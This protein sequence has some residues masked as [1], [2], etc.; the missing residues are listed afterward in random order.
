MLSGTAFLTSSRKIASSSLVQAWY[1]TIGQGQG[2][3]LGMRVEEEARRSGVE[4]TYSFLILGIILLE[5][6][7]GLAFLRGV[8]LGR[9]GFLL[10]VH[11]LVNSE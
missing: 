8:L 11:R 9:Y 2:Q 4:K 3:E 10:D 7:V 6:V 1:R 5:I